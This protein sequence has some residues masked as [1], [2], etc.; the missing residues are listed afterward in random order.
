MM[1]Q[2]NERHKDL[3]SDARRVAVPVDVQISLAENRRILAE[4]RYEL[5]VQR[6][7]GWVVSE[8][9]FKTENNAR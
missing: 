9:I 6:G 4:T 1:P 8:S 3:Q 7:R 5:N 2:K